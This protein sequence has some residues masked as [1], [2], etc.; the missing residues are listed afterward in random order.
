MAQAQ[1]YKWLL[2]LKALRISSSTRED[3]EAEFQY[4][5]V[6]IQSQKGMTQTVKIAETKLVPAASCVASGPEELVCGCHGIRAGVIR[7]AIDEAGASSV[8]ELAEH[9][10]AGA[11]CRS[12]HCRLQRMID[13]RLDRLVLCGSN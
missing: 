1:R 10:G 11:S 8:D 9:T 12:C 13:G 2:I 5:A 7:A 6:E 4:I 3:I